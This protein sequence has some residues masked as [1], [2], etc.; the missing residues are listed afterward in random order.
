MPLALAAHD[1]LAGPPVDI[2]DLHGD[3]FECPQSKA[4]HEQHHCVVAAARNGIGLNRLDEYVHLFGRRM[5]GQ[6]CPISLCNAWNA[7]SKIGGRLPGLEEVA[8]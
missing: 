7:Q 8:E 4:C 2:I 3:Y 6:S 5:S 1:D